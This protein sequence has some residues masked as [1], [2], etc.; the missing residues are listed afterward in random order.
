M[1]QYHVHVVLN[2][3]DQ[4]SLV[5]A[6]VEL[7]VNEVLLLVQLTAVADAEVILVDLQVNCKLRHVLN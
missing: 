7:Q 3:S 4:T 5:G 2:H 1:W 6:E